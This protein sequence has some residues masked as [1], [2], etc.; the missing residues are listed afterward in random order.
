MADRKKVMNEM[1]DKMDDNAK[2][3]ED[4]KTTVEGKLKNIEE[5]TD[6][7]ENTEIDDI[8]AVVEEVEYKNPV[9]Q[10]PKVDREDGI[11]EITNEQI[12]QEHLEEIQVEPEVASSDQ[13]LCLV[14][15]ITDSVVSEGDDVGKTDNS[16]ENL[17]VAKEVD[18]VKETLTAAKVKE[19]VI[20][21][22][23]IVITEEW[24]VADKTVSDK[25]EDITRPVEHEYVTMQKNAQ[26]L[27]ESAKTKP[28]IML[29]RKA[30]EPELEKVVCLSE[31]SSDS[32]C[33]G[34]TSDKPVHEL[35]ALD[36]DANLIQIATEVEQFSDP[37]L[38]IE[39]NIPIEENVP[40]EA[41]PD[42]E[43]INAESNLETLLA[44]ASLQNESVVDT[45]REHRRLSENE[46][47]EKE[48]IYNRQANLLRNE[49][50]QQYLFDAN[51]A[52]SWMSE[53]E[54]YMMVK[55]RGKDE[56][57]ARNF[58]KKHESLEAAV[59]AYADTIRGL[60]ETVK[61]LSAE[62]HPLAEQIAVKQSQL[63][64][65]YAGLKDFSDSNIPGTVGAASRPDGAEEGTEEKVVEES[66]SSSDR[67][68]AEGPANAKYIPI[69][70]TEG[71]G[72]VA[73]SSDDERFK[74]PNRRN[75]RLETKL[76]SSSEDD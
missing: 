21:G 18:S 36:E 22:A 27:L 62:G 41:Q 40:A 1:G 45:T 23:T 9:V 70:S 48:A 10:E 31:E 29:R 49:R 73:D 25:I 42:V 39:E 34:P 57:S 64:K 69:A 46:I 51:E 11:I 28:E 2:K 59:E 72:P 66:V 13:K 20:S 53:Q 65:L 17:P 38:P 12:S 26:N 5:V 63:D 4:L 8:P 7:L 76:V 24:S 30:V 50:E 15:E 32:E 35:P 47:R 75:G 55:D 68:S 19:G 56:T 52:E 6:D 60:G 74:S 16:C 61:G 33:N 43:S 71:E 54:L 67:E 14:E 3:C 37:E 58:M 44:V